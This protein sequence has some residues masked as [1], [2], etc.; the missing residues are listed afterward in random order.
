MI[1]KLK[2][3]NC[4]NVAFLKIIFK[5]LKTGPKGFDP[6]TTGLEVQHSVQAELQAQ[7]SGN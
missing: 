5:T 6:L 4:G 7:I 1:P 2:I 3:I